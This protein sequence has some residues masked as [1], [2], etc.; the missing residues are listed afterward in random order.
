MAKLKLETNNMH[1]TLDH[2]ITVMPTVALHVRELLQTMRDAD[3]REIESYGFTCSH[4]LWRSY[5]NSL[6]KQTAF[7]E[8]KVAAI[9]GVSGV[10][11]GEVGTPWLLTSG[12]VKKISPLRFARIYQNEVDHML[13]LFPKLVNYVASDYG[14]AIRLL[15]II[16]FILHEPQKYGNGV[17]RRFEMN[18]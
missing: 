8:D 4:G 9:W 11:M 7:V 3:R 5:K 10:F 15:D 13:T 14:E 6:Y 17:F 2:T 12:E 16:G 18:K 1:S